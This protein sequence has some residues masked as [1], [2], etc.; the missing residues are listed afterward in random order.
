MRARVPAGVTVKGK[1]VGGTSRDWLQL[2]RSTNDAGR[3]RLLDHALTQLQ[4][5]D[6][7]ERKASKAFDRKESRATGRKLSEA[8]KRV[9]DWA[10]V[11]D[12]ITRRFELDERKKER[13]KK[14]RQA[15]PQ[16]KKREATRKEKRDLERE[17]FEILEEMEEEGESLEWEFS[18]EYLADDS[19]SNVDVNFRLRRRDGKPFGQ[20]EAKQ[21]MRT[22]RA[23]VSAGILAAPPGYRIAGIDWRRPS[24]HQRG[25]SRHGSFPSDL[26]DLTN[27]L[28]IAADHPSLWRLG[29][30]DD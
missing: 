30:I 6:R 19:S 28:Y 18:C 11:V 23:Q 29:G 3:V 26:G 25:W 12:A 24:K 22:F 8:S 21:A 2:I 14:K 17:A 27:V 13:A 10:G 5:A 20:D 16:A 7:D 4:K 9:D 15:T 1:S